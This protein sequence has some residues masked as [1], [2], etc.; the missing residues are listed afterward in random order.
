M[1]TT[2]KKEIKLIEDRIKQLEDCLDAHQK[3][4]IKICAGITEIVEE[5]NTLNN[6]FSML[7]DECEE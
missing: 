4:Q 2:M 6:I 1:G 5:L 3:A 7:E